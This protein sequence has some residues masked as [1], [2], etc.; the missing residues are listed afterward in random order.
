M[1]IISPIKENYLHHE[2]RLEISVDVALLSVLK[3][4]ANEVS[5]ARSSL[6]KVYR[7][8]SIRQNTP[9]SIRTAGQI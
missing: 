1:A 9:R 7:M 5:K 8:V 2:R 6:Q 4:A 3:E